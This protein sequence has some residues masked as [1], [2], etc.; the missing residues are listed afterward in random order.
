ML[1]HQTS[2]DVN[3]WTRTSLAQKRLYVFALRLTVVLL[4]CLVQYGG[5][6]VRAFAVQEDGSLD[7]M[8]SELTFDDHT[9]IELP[10]Q[11]ACRAHC[12]MRHPSAAGLIYVADLGA[13]AIRI[14]QV[15]GG[16]KLVVKKSVKTEPASGP[17][18]LA[19]HPSGEASHTELLSAE[20]MRKQRSP[21]ILYLTFL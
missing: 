13:D 7:Q 20:L 18:Q 8:T 2:T 15:D 10:D 4:L 6:I 5:G 14:L 19:F 9:N 11:A 1:L 17:R 21:H 3:V 16:G 12:V